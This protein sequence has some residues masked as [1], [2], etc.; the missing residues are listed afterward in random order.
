MLQKN[1]AAFR[2]LDERQRLVAVGESLGVHLLLGDL[3][4]VDRLGIHRHEVIH[5]VAA[6]DV[7]Q[8]AGGPE[9]VRGVYV[10][11]VRLVEIEA[12]VTL[13]IIPVRLEVVDIGALGM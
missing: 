13:V 3:Q 1:R 10:A 8:L 9:A 5:L 11:A 2:R 7:Q 4:A 6:V 12:P